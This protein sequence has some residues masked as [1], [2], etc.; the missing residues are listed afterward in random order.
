M[1]LAGLLGPVALRVLLSR[2]IHPGV[3]DPCLVAELWRWLEP[4]GL[5]QV[6]E[7]LLQLLV[8]LHRLGVVGH[9]HSLPTKDGRQGIPDG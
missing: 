2:R 4:L 9:G 1:Q 7:H 8:A 6:L 3:T 5:L